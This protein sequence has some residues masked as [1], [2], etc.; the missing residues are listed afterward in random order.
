M[1]ARWIIIDANN[2][3]HS[4]PSL[5]AVIRR[6][7]PLAR[8]ELV[9][10]MEALLGALADRITVVF[11]GTIG[12]VQ[13][14][15]ESSKVQVRFTSADV[16]ADSAIERLAAGAEDRSS[17]L[18]VSSDRLERHTVE[19]SGVRSL[20]CDLFLREVVSAENE[21]RAAIRCAALSPK[22]KGKLGDFFPSRDGN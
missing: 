17:V 14:G 13:T 16:S 22:P 10:R 18:V 1:L 15:F 9:R 7:F 4:D 20:S 8:N 5:A 12:G 3:M 19:A 2:L 21:L 11:D 6:D